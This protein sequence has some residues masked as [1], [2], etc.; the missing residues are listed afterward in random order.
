[1]TSEQL[2]ALGVDYLNLKAI[3]TPFARM[4]Y[5]DAIIALQKRGH[6]IE[7]GEDLSNDHELALGDMAGGPIFITHYPAELRFFTMKASRTDPRLIEC[8]DLLLPGVGE[9]MGASETETD[10]D[11]LER[12]LVSSRSLRQLLDLGGTADDYS[13][14]LAMHRQSTT[15]QAG[16]AMAFERL[17]RF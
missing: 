12:K 2:A 16:F 4:T 15:Q 17:F 9:V 7:W 3:K 10:P 13:R 6:F 11:L 5:D 1:M 14:Y 8:C